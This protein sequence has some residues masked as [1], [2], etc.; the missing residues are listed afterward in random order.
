MIAYKLPEL[1]KALALA[2]RR[3]SVDESWRVIHGVLNELISRIE[4]LITRGEVVGFDVED[5]LRDHSVRVL[6]SIEDGDVSM[7]IAVLEELSRKLKQVE[8]RAYI[9]YTHV[10]LA[11]LVATLIVVGVGAVMALSYLRAALLI[12]SILSII[13][14]GVGIGS[15]LLVL[16]RNA[17]LTLLLAVLLQLLVIPLDLITGVKVESSMIL[18]VLSLGSITA[19]LVVQHL[20][21]RL[22]TS[23]TLSKGSQ[24]A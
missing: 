17:H 11:R 9:A 13:S 2:H 6:R 12:Q 3:S 8:S 21:R 22:L 23:S 18:L 4:V 16:R 20:M 5:E 14:I 15:I 19:L 10:V 24:V 7:A 1:Y